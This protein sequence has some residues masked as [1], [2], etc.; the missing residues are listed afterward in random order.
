MIGLMLPHPR[1]KIF[2]GHLERLAG[3]VHC[4]H[5]HF[6]RPSHGY[7][8][9][10]QRETSLFGLVGAKAVAEPRIDAD[11]IVTGF[12]GQVAHEEPNRLSHLRGRQPDA[13]SLAHQFEQ[14]TRQGGKAVVEPLDRLTLFLQNR[15]R[16]KDDPE[17]R[18]VDRD[19]VRWFREGACD[20][21]G[22]GGLLDT[23]FGLDSIRCPYVVKGYGCSSHGLGGLIALPRAYFGTGRCRGQVTKLARKSPPTARIPLIL[24]S[25]SRFMAKKT[26]GGSGESNDSVAR[27]LT[28]PD[29]QAKGKKWFARARELGE[30]RQFDYAIEYY[31][32]GLEFWPDAVEEACKPLHGCAVARRQTGGKKPGFK[33][34]MRRSMTDKDAKRAFLNSA[35]LFG[36]DPDN[37]NYIEGIIKATSRLRADDAAKWA[38]GICLKALETV[39]KVN[40]KQFLALTDMLE[41]VGDRAA[42]R[43]EAAFGVELFELGLGALNLWRR[44]LPNDRSV[45]KMLKNLS[46]KLTILKG[47]YKDGNSFR[48]SIAGKEEQDDLRDQKR[49]IQSDE[50]VAELLAKAEETFKQNPDDGRTL[51]ALID[52]LCRREAKEGE[53][54]AI[55]ILLGEYERTDEYSR[56]QMADDIRMKQLGRSLREAVKSGDQEAI[57][58]AHK[59][60]LRFD[61]AAFKERVERYPTDNRMKFEYAVRQFRA[62]RFDE[63]IP[64]FQA[65]RVDAKNRTACAMYLGRCFF[66]KQYYSQ[67]ISALQDELATY[68]FS[69]NDLAKTMNYWLARAQEASG[70]APA[71]R[72]TYGKI[73]QMDY[74]YKDVRGR[75]D[76]VEPTG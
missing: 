4:L 45:E 36:H 26:K 14:A 22:R 44:R 72:E 55:D 53:Q 58:E 5:D 50:R 13:L 11:E 8:D 35:W 1:L 70:D 33:D 12:A 7:G 10:G 68:E 9:S 69:D 41:E 49:Y 56:K 61:L 67:A 73:L 40:A 27:L 46:T 75:L 65:A 47:R 20:W 62:G 60:S 63:S 34:T 24:E 23:A 74:N 28:T 37:I 18:K 25:C 19:H 16:I 51:K 71:A 43:G 38:A 21:Q 39:T 15:V 42:E 48:D 59:A 29:D 2:P 54:R 64:M 66:R 52:L 57:K 17:A 76:T 32:S 3:N 31:V 30:K 6:G